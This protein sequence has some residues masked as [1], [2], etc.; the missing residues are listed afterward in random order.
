[1]TCCYNSDQ[2]TENIPG[3]LEEDCHVLSTHH[4]HN[5]QHLNKTEIF[6]QNKT[7][8]IPHRRHRWYIL[9]MLASPISSINNF[10]KINKTRCWFSPI[11]PTYSYWILCSIYAERRTPKYEQ[12]FMTLLSTEMLQFPLIIW[13]WSKELNRQISFTLLVFGLPRLANTNSLI[14]FSPLH[15]ISGLATDRWRELISLLGK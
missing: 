5:L 8:K 10:G 11:Q 9:K 4:L 15:L 12:Y 6:S 14:G 13:V 3:K 2:Q 1:M 7:H